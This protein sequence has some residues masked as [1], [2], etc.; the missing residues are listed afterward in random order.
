MTKMYLKFLFS[1]LNGSKE[2]AAARTTE[3]RI[4]SSQG[5]QSLIWAVPGEISTGKAKGYVQL[6]RDKVV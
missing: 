2:S 4:P 3:I 5:P 6:L 1:S